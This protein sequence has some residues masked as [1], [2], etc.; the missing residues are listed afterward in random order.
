MNR[1]AEDGGFFPP[2]FRRIFAIKIVTAMCARVVR[3]SDMIQEGGL[4]NVTKIFGAL[5][6]PLALMLAAV[7]VVTGV[8]LLGMPRSSVTSNAA[9]GDFSGP[10]GNVL[11]RTAGPITMM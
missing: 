8:Q 5:R 6:R 4:M 2:S 10:T 1:A 7:T 3:V 9:G 11:E